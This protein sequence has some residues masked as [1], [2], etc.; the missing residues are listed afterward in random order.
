MYFFC[1]SAKLLHFKME[2][3]K[4]LNLD[5]LALSNE[6]NFANCDSKP[7]LKVEDEPSSNGNPVKCEI[8][9][10]GSQLEVDV[11]KTPNPKRHEKIHSNIKQ[12][13]CN[14]CDKSFK[15]KTDLK[16]FIQT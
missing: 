2:D 3:T 16:I 4:I 8:D 10:K 1:I 12:F 5:G 11:D 13:Q 14:T 9:V 15:T 7:S 6:L